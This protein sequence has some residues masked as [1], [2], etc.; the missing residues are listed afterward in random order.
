M[1]LYIF[2]TLSGSKEEFKPLE[3]NSV[4]MFVCGQTVYDDAHLGHAKTYIAFDI[5]ARW[6]RHLGY[7]LKYIQNITDVEDKIIARA[8]ERNMDPMDL[9]EYYETR[10]FEDMESIGVKQDVDMYPK[11]SEYIDTI[12][13]QIQALADNGYAYYLDGDIYYDVSK[14]ADYT[15]LSRMNI[16]ELSNH[17]IEPK[18]GK[19]NSYDFALWKAAKPGEPKWDVTIS[20]DGKEVKLSGRPGWHIEDT[21]MTYALF[22]PQ[23][24]I[25][26]GAREL[27]FPHHTNE[28]AQAEAAY[29]VKP[30]VRY[31][32]HSGMLNIRGQEMHK[33]LKNF[34]PIRDFVK[35]HGAEML[36]FMVAS[37][38]YRKEIN[39]T[40]SYMDLARRNLYYIYSSF[41][42]LYNMKASDSSGDADQYV[43]SSAKN[44]LNEF[45]S[46]MNDDFNTPLALS[47]LLIFVKDLRSLASSGKSISKDAKQ[48]AIDAVLEC[49]SIIGILAGDGYKKPLEEGIYKLIEEREILRKAGEFSEADAIRKRLLDEYGTVVEDTEYGPLWYRRT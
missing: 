22:G 16:E 43:E 48:H 20:I 17:R 28:I 11:S 7:K 47:K 2:N 45:S 27:I 44:F 32:M 3:G 4:K 30:F 24:D 42:I 5:V 14:F 49:A 33:S 35:E 8:H 38:H 21:A 25:H 18:E 6:I 13:D 26:G 9:A 29:G 37:T 15:K 23:Y 36:R 12:R 19:R 46:A 1:A 39:F 41:N 34:V 31:W 40:D 10:F